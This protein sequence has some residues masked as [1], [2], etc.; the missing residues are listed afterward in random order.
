MVYVME[1]AVV[2]SLI[3]L[4][5]ILVIGSVFLSLRLLN[6]PNDYLTGYLLH[7]SIGIFGIL[8][9]VLLSVLKD[10]SVAATAVISSIVAYSLGAANARR[11]LPALAE[12]DADS[13]PRQD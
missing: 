2:I 4:S 5:A 13:C 6:K 10:L 8:A 1:Y 7:F 12:T 3:A 11:S 9:V